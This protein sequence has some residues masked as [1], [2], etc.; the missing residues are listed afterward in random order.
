MALLAQSLRAN[1]SVETLSLGGNR[2]TDEAARSLASL[3][4]SGRS[5]LKVL[6]MADVTPKPARY[7]TTP[8]FPGDTPVVSVGMSWTHAVRRQPLLR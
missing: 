6:N 8:S 2:L 4:R 1:I 7:V 5:S 3:L